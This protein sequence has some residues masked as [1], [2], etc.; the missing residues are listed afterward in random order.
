MN[1][2]QIRMESFYLNFQNFAIQNNI[3]ASTAGFTIGMATIYMF[4]AIL[5]RLGF[6]VEDIHYNMVKEL[7]EWMQIILFILF[8]FLRWAII[9]LITFIFTFY[10][11]RII[12]EPQANELSKQYL[13]KKDKEQVVSTMN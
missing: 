3:L 7:P 12:I 1:I 4:D 11:F 6:N 10:I 13:Q 9:V 5:E 2:K 8:Q